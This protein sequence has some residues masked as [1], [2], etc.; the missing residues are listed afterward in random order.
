MVQWI[1]SLYNVIRILLHFR[2]CCVIVCD[3]TIFTRSLL[4][5]MHVD[6]GTEYRTTVLLETRET[7]FGANLQNTYEKKEHAHNWRFF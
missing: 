3:T 7:R 1:R 2:P 5:N 4:F 6:F